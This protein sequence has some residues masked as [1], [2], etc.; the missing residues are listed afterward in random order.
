MPE[1][2]QYDRSAYNVTVLPPAP[3]PDDFRWVGMRKR[4]AS[5]DLFDCGDP[6]NLAVLIASYHTR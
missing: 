6:Q 3:R 5:A 4:G 1:L 2:M